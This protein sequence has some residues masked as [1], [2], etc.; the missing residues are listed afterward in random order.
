MISLALLHETLNPNPQKFTSPVFKVV[1]G[2]CDHLSSANLLFGKKPTEEFSQ[3][4]RP[5]T[6]LFPIWKQCHCLTHQWLRLW[7]SQAEVQSS[8]SGRKL[9]QIRI[10]KVEVCFSPIFRSPELTQIIMDVFDYLEF[11]YLSVLPRL[12]PAQDLEICTVALYR[13]MSR[14][15]H[16]GS[17]CPLH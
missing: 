14:A 12:A 11:I 8:A 7:Q 6:L 10:N 5:L 13:A 15:Y 9:G 3:V 1:T 4:F 16:F 2:R 17:P